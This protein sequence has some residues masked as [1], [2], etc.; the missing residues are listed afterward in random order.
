MVENVQTAGEDSIKIGEESKDSNLLSAWRRSG[1]FNRIFS[2]MATREVRVLTN[3]RQT[4][5]GG[6][7]MSPAGN[8]YFMLSL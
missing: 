6:R 5:P 4:T 1:R 8:F 3:E 2:R 7:H